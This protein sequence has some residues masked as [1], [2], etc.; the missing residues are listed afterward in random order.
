MTDLPKIDGA[1]YTILCMKGRISTEVR[2]QV[3]FEN[4]STDDTVFSLFLNKLS[5]YP[6]SLSSQNSDTQGYAKS[7]YRNSCVVIDV[8]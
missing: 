3:P 7:V 4:R 2:K 6:V 1:I 5:V 8:G